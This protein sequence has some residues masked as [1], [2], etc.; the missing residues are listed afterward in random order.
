MKEFWEEEKSRFNSSFQFL[1][2][3]H[4]QI[5]N[6]YNVVYFLTRLELRPTFNIN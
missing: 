3:F 4:I 6:F 5:F 2:Y 1:I